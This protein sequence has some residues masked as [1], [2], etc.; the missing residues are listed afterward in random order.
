MSKLRKVVSN[1]A[2]IAIGPY[3]QAVI[4][5][6]HVYV[7]GMLGMHPHTMDFVS[8][9]VLEQAKQAFQNMTELLT[10][11]GSGMDKVIKCEIFV[12]DMNDFMILNQLYG[13]IFVWDPAPVRQTLEVSALPRWA[14]VMISC[15]AY[16]EN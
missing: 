11:A 7:A 5:G 6:N 12:T 14:K 9:D 15:I 16:I 13:E 10:E 1:K 8:D 4:H 2:P 3:S